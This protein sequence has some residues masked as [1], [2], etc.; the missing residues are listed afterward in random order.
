LDGM[1][2][3]DAAKADA[4]SGGPSLLSWRFVVGCSCCVIKPS[5][6]ES[7]LGF[8]LFRR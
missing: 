8:S 5:N 6:F 4:F 7:D 3:N 1:E 2:D